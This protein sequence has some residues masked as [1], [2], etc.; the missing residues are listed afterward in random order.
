MVILSTKD[1]LID[2]PSMVITGDGE[3]DLKRDRLEGNIIVSPLVTLDRTIDKIPIL[4]NILQ[5]REKG[6]LSVA[7]KVKGPT[8][9]P[10]ISV[11]F[12]NTI[13]GKALNI[14]RNILVLPKELLEGM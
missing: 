14:L 5:G 8:D 1:F 11:S 6:F 13:G 4:R 12:V 3:V 7:Y 9:D 2:S 10:D